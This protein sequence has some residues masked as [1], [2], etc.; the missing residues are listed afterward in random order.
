MLRFFCFRSIFRAAKTTTT[1]RYATF[2]HAFW[3]RFVHKHIR[4]FFA[5]IKDTT[6][7]VS[8]D[9]K[10]QGEARPPAYAGGIRLVIVQEVDNPQ[11]TS[12][13][14]PFTATPSALTSPALP[15]T[16]QSQTR[17]FRQLPPHQSALQ[18]FKHLGVCG[19]PML[20]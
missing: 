4:F 5:T 11:E 3:G 20:R 18:P 6:F 12:S 1:T 14:R 16:V 7:L 19:E 2:K 10:K 9:T 8:V 13:P 17:D 15:G